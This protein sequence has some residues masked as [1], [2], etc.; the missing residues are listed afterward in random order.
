MGCIRRN[1][2]LVLQLEPND[3]LLF[4]YHLINL[5]MKT[6][7]LSNDLKIAQYTYIYIACQ[8]Y[9]FYLYNEATGEIEENQRV[10]S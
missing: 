1:N 3:G 6:C 5:G 10:S 8:V 9:I 2:N 4:S 7:S